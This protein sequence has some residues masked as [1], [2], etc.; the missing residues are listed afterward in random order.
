MPGPAALYDLLLDRIV[1][2]TPVE[3]VLIGRHWTLCRAGGI[4]LGATPADGGVR[5]WHGRL[6]G[7]SVHELTSWVRSW[8]RLQAAV[9]MAAI[10]ASL[11]GDGPGDMPPPVAVVKGR[12]AAGAVLDWFRP[13]L[14]GARTVVVG[15]IPGLVSAAGLDVTWLPGRGGA[16]EPACEQALP[17]AEWVFVADH[18]LADKTLP[19][20]LELAAGAKVVL[21]GPGVP[22]LPELSAFGIDYLAGIAFDE[23]G[24]LRH[25]IAEG[26]DLNA[27]DAH[28]H[29]R[30]AAIGTVGEAPRHAAGWSRSRRR[31]AV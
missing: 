8:N 17:Q 3:E 11:Q 23:P 6:A 13:Q 26:G 27:L 5:P 28:L 10:N 9:G 7:R 2:A 30:I 18:T 19:R 21:M 29:Y 24:P 4:G 15:D 1:A 25:T 14:R 16:L 22:W 12:S 20:V 31:C